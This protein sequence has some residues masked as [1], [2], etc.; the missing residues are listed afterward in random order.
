MGGWVG[1][2]V[3]FVVCTGLRNAHVA[4]NSY[5]STLRTSDFRPSV[6]PSVLPCL[7]P[8]F[9]TP[10]D[11]FLRLHAQVLCFYLPIRAQFECHILSHDEYDDDDD[12]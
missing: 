8:F 5:T 9:L 10:F 7:P 12:C 3:E 6:R 11:P 1:G 2:L 4:I